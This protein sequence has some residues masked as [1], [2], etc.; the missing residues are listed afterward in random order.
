MDGSIAHIF[1]KFT[2]TVCHIQGS[3]FFIICCLEIT[4]IG[5]FNA[6]SIRC[7]FFLLFNGRPFFFFFFCCCKNW[8]RSDHVPHLLYAQI[9]TIIPLS[10]S[11][12]WAL[13]MKMFLKSSLLSI[14]AF[15][16]QS[17]LFVNR[18]FVISA[19]RSDYLNS[20]PL[21][22]LF[23]TVYLELL[24]NM[25]RHRLYGTRPFG[26]GWCNILKFWCH[27]LKNCW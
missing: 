24:R 9:Y 23:D 1:I 10:M 27:D 13:G 4:S 26:C 3:F 12:F 20:I 18:V 6:Q 7:F 21:I 17:V 15:A 8:W 25:K 11:N 2:R 19:H 16:N 22:T 5:C 14:T